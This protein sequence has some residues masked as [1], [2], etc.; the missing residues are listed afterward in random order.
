M[1]S[2]KKRGCIFMNI[3][4]KISIDK[5]MIIAIVTYIIDKLL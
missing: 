4:I 3:I 1:L 5:V 2:N